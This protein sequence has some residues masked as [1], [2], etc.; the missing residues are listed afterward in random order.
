MAPGP[1]IVVSVYQVG[2]FEQEIFVNY[3]HGASR[4]DG[5]DLRRKFALCERDPTIDFELLRVLISDEEHG[6]HL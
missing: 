4:V 1:G 2:V 5:S 3:R 6:F